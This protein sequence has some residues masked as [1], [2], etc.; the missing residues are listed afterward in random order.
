[1]EFFISTLGALL[2]Q[3][4]L[5]ITWGIGITFTLI[6]WKKHPTVSAL[7]LT[8]FSGFI[9][10]SILDIFFNISLP[11]IMLEQ[12][13]GP[14]QAAQFFII[15]TAVSS[16]LHTVFWVVL[17]IALFGW[18]QNNQKLEKTE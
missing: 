3:T 12:G 7:A 4:P 2:P 16:I 1:M 9:V 18:R 15:K 11:G 10:L 8:A 17:M 14:A 6:F 5:L 13:L